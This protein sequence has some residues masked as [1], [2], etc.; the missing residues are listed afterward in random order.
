M[1]IR[2]AKRFFV[3]SGY[4]YDSDSIRKKNVETDYTFFFSMNNKTMLFKHNICFLHKTNS[5]FIIS[6]FQINEL[7]LKK[8]NEN[9]LILI[10]HSI[11][12]TAEGGLL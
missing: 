5:T 11:T 10:V 2:A 12:Q 9:A 1:N 6:T 4:A 7:K 8:I 3:L